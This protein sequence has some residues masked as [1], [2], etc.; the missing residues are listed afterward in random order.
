METPRRHGGHGETTDILASA[1]LCVLCG[2][3]SCVRPTA[4]T[5]ASM[6][7]EVSGSLG[8]RRGGAGGDAQA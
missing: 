3:A 5:L 8:R 7:R 2:Q 1:I 4:A 6:W